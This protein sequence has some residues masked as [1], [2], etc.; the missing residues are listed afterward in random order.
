MRHPLVHLVSL[1]VSRTAPALALVGALAAPAGLAS[2]G[3]AAH[4]PLAA[5]PGA[6][7][8]AAAHA[9]AAPD[10]RYYGSSLQVDSAH[11]LVA[12][13]VQFLGLTSV[14]GR[15]K[16][17]R[18]TIWFSPGDVTRSSISVVIKAA[19]LD[20]AVELRD[21]DLRSDAFFEVDKYPVITFTSTR[22]DRGPGGLTATGQ[23][24]LHGVTR[25]VAIPFSVVAE[26]GKDPWGNTRCALSGGFV[27]NRG[28][29][30]VGGYG[31]FAD[32]GKRAIGD[33][34]TVRLLIQAVRWN[35]EHFTL[36]RRSLAAALLPALADRGVPAA[37]ARYRELKRDHPG[38]YD[39]SARQ[40]E[41]LGQ[42]LLGR[43]QLDA[44]VA[45][46]RLNAEAYPASSEMHSDLA[47]G[48]A[49]AGQR[50][51]ALASCAKALALD[52][53]NT[54]AI[55]LKRRLLEEAGP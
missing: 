41:L 30:G 43:R 28:D 26:P 13:G 36:D 8:A 50:D 4:T 35:I 6:P 45:V 49:S 32:M 29:Y 51:A 7:D 5:A 42:L 24:T 53:E 46:F 12:F 10:D 2:A 40:L 3:T 47:L 48:L 9:G 16:D 17:F 23:L 54:D 52:P 34:V 27:I 1:A 55:E 19:S 11:S 39:F 33:E 20:T 25:Q 37:V 38:D 14:E 31:R 18:G 21:K 44:A 15:F 22:I